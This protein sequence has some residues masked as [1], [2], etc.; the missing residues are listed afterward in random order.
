[1]ATAYTPGLKVSAREVIKKHRILPIKGEVL[2]QVGERVEPGTVVA[3]TYL[4]GKVQIVNVA[5]RLGVDQSEVPEKMAKK[6]G[7]IINVGDIIAKSTSF[8]GLF[9]SEIKSPVSGTVESVSGITG[10]VIVRGEPQPIEVKAYLEA[11]V[12]E[13][14]AGEGVV[15]K[16]EGAYVQG[17]FGIGG[18]ISGELVMACDSPS[19]VLDTETIKSEHAGKIIA[20]G[21][22]VTADALKKAIKLGVKGVVTGGFDDQDLRDFLGYDLGVAI[23]GHEALGIT[24][25]VTEGFGQIDM[26]P[27]TF[28]LLKQLEGNNASMNGAT[29][30]RAGVIRPEVIVPMKGSASTESDRNVEAGQLNPGT[31]LRVIR[32]P[33]FG[34]L[35]KVISLPS[36]PHVLESGSKARVVEVETSEG[37]KLILPRANVEIIED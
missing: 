30:I 23:T 5:N 1:M 20:G 10:Q 19:D 9:K 37:E 2:A 36:E 28:S 17:I 16:T 34:W 18:E 13:V 25:I 32:S 31:P 22:L 14:I 35:V 11:E 8:F 15:L 12:V 27:R 33:Y 21:S 6:E 7:E 24:L 26:A 3:R 29:Q 4:P